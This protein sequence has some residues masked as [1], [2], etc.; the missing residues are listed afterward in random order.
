MIVWPIT[1]RSE[2]EQAGDYDSGDNERCI[3]V[4]RTD[5]LDIREEKRMV[6]DEAHAT[7]HGGLGIGAHND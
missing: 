2:R 5:H 1:S 7:C 6:W 3:Q 4:S